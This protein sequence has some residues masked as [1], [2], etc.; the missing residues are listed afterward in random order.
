MDTTAKV[1]TDVIIMIA[2]VGGFAMF[3]LVG[4]TV[5]KYFE[6]R[7]IR[8]RELERKEWREIVR[9]AQNAARD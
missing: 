7:E 2:A 8:K 5:I 6:R 1:I 3:L 4:D 9:R